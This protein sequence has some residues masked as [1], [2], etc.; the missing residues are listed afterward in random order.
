MRSFIRLHLYFQNC[1]SGKAGDMER[2]TGLLLSLVLLEEQIINSPVSESLE[3]PEAKVALWL[4]PGDLSFLLSLCC[5]R[6]TSAVP[7]C[8]R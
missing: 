3:R 4:C 1:T 5:P 8:G 7:C 2:G 6:H